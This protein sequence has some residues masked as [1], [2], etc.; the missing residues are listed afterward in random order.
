M[1]PLLNPPFPTIA[2]SSIT[3]HC[4]FFHDVP[5]PYLPFPTIALSSL[6]T[7]AYLGT[8][9]NF[10][11]IAYSVVVVVL[12]MYIVLA[13]FVAILLERFAG[14]EDDTFDFDDHADKVGAAPLRPD[15]PS[16]Q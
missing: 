8:H 2:L 1:L 15:A 6:S 14:Q 3:C 11:T 9:G 10:G 5:L 4:L 7:D 13:L 16:W 12:G